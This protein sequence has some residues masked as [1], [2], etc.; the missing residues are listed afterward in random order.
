MKFTCERALLVNALSV[1][2]HT[3]SPKSPIAALEGI[4]IHAG[5]KLYVSGYNLETGITVTVPAEI[6]EQGKCVMPARLFFDIIRKM[7]DDEVSVTVDENFKVSIRGEISSFTISAMTAED[8]PEL[9]DVEYDNEFILPQKA[10]RELIGGTLFCVSEDRSRRPIYTGALMEVAHESITM[11]SID[12]FRLAMRRYFFDKPIE[13]AC[14]FVVPSSALKEVEKI[15]DESDDPAAF[16]LGKKYIL[17]KVGAVTLVCR[18]LEGDFGDW[19]QFVPQQNPILL[20]AA[21]TKLIA[22]IDRVGLLVSEKFKSPIRC[23]FSYNKAE[24]RTVNNMGDAYDVCDIAGDGK[25]L[26]IGFNCRYLIDAL[27]ASSGD[28]V[29][30]ELS[31]GLSPIVITPCD[32]SEKF[33]YMVLPVRLKA[34]Q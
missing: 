1:A 14:K 10:L 24:F 29:V 4:H 22:T 19:R 33:A 2:S 6:K 30:L 20:T 26:E 32:G 7:P 9:P 5:V 13:R 8:Y 34:E 21:R 15:L 18:R 3:V 31:N 25:E 23:M 11:V 17:F 16:T 28:E 12:G 27:K